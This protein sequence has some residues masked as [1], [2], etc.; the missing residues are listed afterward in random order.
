MK[1]KT[2]PV[3]LIYLDD[4]LDLL[5]VFRDCMA[6]ESLLIRTFSDPIAAIEDARRSPPDLFLLDFQLRNTT[7]IKVGEQLDSSIPKYLIS[8]NLNLEVP[9]G[10][11]AVLGKPFDFIMLEE[12]ISRTIKKKQTALLRVG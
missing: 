10:F 1:N 7:G 6:S 11:E 8:G 3:Q 12:L 2:N 5:A 4:E 9:P